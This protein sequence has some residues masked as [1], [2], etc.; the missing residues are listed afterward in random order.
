MAEIR[1]L[2]EYY[3]ALG[4]GEGDIEKGLTQLGTKAKPKDYF[5]T[6]DYSRLLR[7][8]RDPSGKGSYLPTE[9]TDSLDNS[10]ENA[11]ANQQD[12]INVIKD[13]LRDKE[14]SYMEKPIEGFNRPRLENIF[15]R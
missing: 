9:I 6:K 13:A 1:Q 10:I 7:I 4:F 3:S 15:G 8:I 2:N 5:S 14:R 11:F 12:R